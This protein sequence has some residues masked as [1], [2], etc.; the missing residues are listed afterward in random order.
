MECKS[1]AVPVMPCRDPVTDIF[2]KDGIKPFLDLVDFLG[3]SIS[4]RNPPA[5]YRTIFEHWNE[6][7]YPLAVLIFVLILAI[8]Y[9][10]VKLIRRRYQRL[11]TAVDEYQ[12][13]ESI[14][15]KNNAVY[16]D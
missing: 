4:L 13:T 15:V 9:Y 8:L 14:V 1:A 3:K 7:V 16:E 10:T 11:S 12:M 6:I 2:K 5:I